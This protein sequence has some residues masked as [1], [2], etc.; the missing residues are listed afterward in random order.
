MATSSS[1]TITTKPDPG[2]DPV[3]PP[4]PIGAQAN[5]TTT[6][7]P[8]SATPVKPGATFDYRVTT[9]NNG[10]SV[11]RNAKV[12]D[13]LPAGLS[14]VSS[15]DGCTASGQTVTCGPVASLA[16]GASKAWVFTVKLDPA[17]T[18]DGSDLKN[19]ATSSSDTITIKPDPG[20]D[21]VTPPGPITP[22]ANLTTTKAATTTTPVSPGETFDYKVTVTNNGPS[23]A[24]NV[25]APDP[26]PAS[27]S[28]V[29]SVDGC[30]GPVGVN[31]ATV[32]CGPVPSLAPG[33]SKTWVFTVR[34]DPA[35]VGDGSDVANV[36]TPTSDTEGTKLPNDPAGGLPGSKPAPAVADLQLTASTP[37]PLIARGQVAT[38]VFTAK[39]KG[40]SVAQH[41]K[42]T[43]TLPVG[44]GFVVAG[45][46][47]ACTGTG[48]TVVCTRHPFEVTDPDYTVNLSTGAETPT[49]FT[50]PGVI[51][52]ETADSI[53]A[54]NQAEVTI[55]LEVPPPVPAPTPLART[56]A[57]NLIEAGETAVL[58]VLSGAGALA[59][60]RRRRALLTR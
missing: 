45:S 16:V 6:K 19:V 56:G 60:A 32:T 2:N 33:T 9:T 17:Y 41:A 4:G 8:T 36:V 24:K 54:N 28:F 12:T 47:P 59:V 35:Y 14:F 34:L 27:L 25:T 18:G 21:P 3:L 23:V 13:P 15:V 38:A 31:G 11:A 37:T 20:N 55:R 22:E 40:P 46:D 48:R 5:L 42:V 10:P 39:N 52:S 7:A 53:P 29:S 44:V 51:S 1:D 49:A 58:L 26:L 43:I 57:G 30:T 50:V